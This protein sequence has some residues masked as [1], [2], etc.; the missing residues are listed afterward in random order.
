[1]AKIAARGHF[2]VLVSLLH[3]MFIKKK[4]SW[5]F[6][7]QTFD[8]STHKYWNFWWFPIQILENDRSSSAFDLIVI[9]SV[10]SKWYR[11][12]FDGNNDTP[13][14]FSCQ[15][16]WNLVVYRNAYAW[17][18]INVMS[19]TGQVNIEFWSS[20]LKLIRSGLMSVCMQH[21]MMATSVMDGGW[22]LLYITYNYITHIPLINRITMV[23]IF[24]YK[25]F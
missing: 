9:L 11:Y 10:W 25:L 3:A 13:T 8:D 18:C 12:E 4:L 24:M 14:D 2:I 16:D 20:I 15:T 19:K 7:I 5:W 22:L 17:P 23:Y 6:C 1:M 21:C